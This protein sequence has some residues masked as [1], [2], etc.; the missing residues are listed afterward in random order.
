MQGSALLKKRLWHSFF[1]AN[2]VK[3]L[4]IPFY[5]KHLWSLFLA[6]GLSLLALRLVKDYLQNR[7]QRIKIGSFYSDWEDFASGVP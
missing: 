7:A 2:F 1:L 5:V 6:C 4:R 3:F